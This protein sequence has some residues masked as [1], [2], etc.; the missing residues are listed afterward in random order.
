MRERILQCFVVF[1]QELWFENCPF[2]SRDELSTFL[3]EMDTY[4]FYETAVGSRGI[5]RAMKAMQTVLRFR[6]Q[7]DIAVDSDIGSEAKVAFDEISSSGGHF[8]VFTTSREAADLHESR[9]QRIENRIT[10]QD[11]RIMLHEMEI[12]DLKRRINALF[13]TAEQFEN[14]DDDDDDSDGDDSDEDSGDCDAEEGEEDSEGGGDEYEDHGDTDNVN[15]FGKRDRDDYDD[16]EDW[17][18]DDEKLDDMNIFLEKLASWLIFY[19]GSSNAGNE[20]YMI[21]IQMLFGLDQYQLRQLEEA[22]RKDP[23][24]R[25]YITGGDAKMVG[26]KID[27]MSPQDSAEEFD[28][29]QFLLQESIDIARRNGDDKSAEVR[30][31]IALVNRLKRGGCDDHDIRN[32]LVCVCSKMLKDSVKYRLHCEASESCRTVSILLKQTAYGNEFISHWP[33]S[34]L[35][36]GQKISMGH[37]LPWKDAGPI[38]IDASRDSITIAWPKFGSCDN[39]NLNFKLVYDVYLC[40]TPTPGADDKEFQRR[41]VWKLYKEEC[42]PPNYLTVTGLTERFQYFF[43][44][45]ARSA[46]SATQRMYSTFSPISQGYSVDD[47][48]LSTLA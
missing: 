34:T 23:K 19:G 32:G 22:L 45:R 40:L 33:F 46:P 41:Q 3:W 5:S 36:I 37:E 16:D 7:S 30:G 24:D 18:F 31:V 2:V 1:V 42:P 27:I 39:L 47:F 21:D 29:Y 35:S 48:D 8:D 9:L 20:I 10:D 25:F 13:P 11:H 44:V 38:R 15:Q 12:A 43:R 26:L 6:E 28:K 4:P 14:D 17:D